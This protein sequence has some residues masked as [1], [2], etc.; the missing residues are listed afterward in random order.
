MECSCSTAIFQIPLVASLTHSHCTTVARS[1]SI[2]GSPR[3]GPASLGQPAEARTHHER[4]LQ[5]AKTV[6]PEFQRNWITTL[7]EKLTKK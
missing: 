2:A 4:A 1:E 6:E 7:E 5:L 3:R